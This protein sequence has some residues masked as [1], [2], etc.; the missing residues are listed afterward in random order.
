MVNPA[1]HLVMPQ[2][3]VVSMPKH[4]EAAPGIMPFHR[5]LEAQNLVPKPVP[6][7]KIHP[8]HTPEAPAITR[9]RDTYHPANG[10]KLLPTLGEVL[11]ATPTAPPAI[12]V[13]QTRQVQRPATGRLLDLYL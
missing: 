3:M 6:T 10:A 2:R 7:P 12:K 1:H 8:P 11:P 4:F 5:M 13:E 9:P